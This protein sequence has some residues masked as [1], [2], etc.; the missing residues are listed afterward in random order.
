MT[1]PV[2][3][4]HKKKG[5]KKVQK[6]T[7][8][9]CYTD[10]ALQKKDKTNADATFTQQELDTLFSRMNTKMPYRVPS[11]VSDIAKKVGES[12][13]G[14]IGEELANIHKLIHERGVPFAGFKLIQ[15]ID[16]DGS[17]VLKVDM[18]EEAI[19]YLCQLEDNDDPNH[20]KPTT[21]SNSQHSDSASLATSSQSVLTPPNE[22]PT[23]SE[24]AGD[25]KARSILEKEKGNDM[26]QKRQF[27]KAVEYYSQ[28]I[29][30]DPENL[31]F[32]MNRAGTA[33]Y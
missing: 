17:T 31:V 1:K 7:Q 29:A 16:D 18:T 28:A 15:S 12:E 8:R 32:Y 24:D 4:S 3:K 27:G 26:Y 2:K 23:T 22:T 21:P 30:L 9:G 25:P 33:Q 20:N 11:I 10:L 13:A 14:R 6:K 5:K 19:R